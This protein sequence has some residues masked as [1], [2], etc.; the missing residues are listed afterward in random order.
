M[1]NVG[2]LVIQNLILVYM[3]TAMGK[4]LKF[5]LRT[6]NENAGSIG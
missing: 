2:D 4:I 1:Q 3:Y 5:Y 6:M